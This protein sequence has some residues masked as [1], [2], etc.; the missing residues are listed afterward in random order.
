MSQA[1]QRRRLFEDETGRNFG[2]HA[3]ETSLS[4][5]SFA[6]PPLSARSA[7]TWLQL[8]GSTSIMASS[9]VDALVKTPGAQILRSVDE[10]GS[11]KN[12]SAS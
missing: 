9:S 5:E 3:G 6:E 7:E 8:L 12:P 11:A 2:Q 10:L 1:E 4:F